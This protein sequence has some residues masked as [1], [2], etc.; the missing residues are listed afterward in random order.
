MS[1]RK[2]KKR[3]ADRK[4]SP[5]TVSFKMHR[6][7]G[8]MLCDSSCALKLLRGGVLN[9]ISKGYNIEFDFSDIRFINSS[10]SNALF[11]NLVRLKGFEI[12]P[13]VIISNA[14]DSVKMELKS[15]FKYGVQLSK[16]KQQ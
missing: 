6:I 12:I 4:R 13:R 16:R 1:R 2:F 11:A 10:Y 5:K 3:Y 9:E 8:N 15:A 14:K 7:F